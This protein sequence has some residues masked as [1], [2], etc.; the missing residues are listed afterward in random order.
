MTGSFSVT[1]KRALAVVTVVALGFGAYFLR[2]Y[3]LLI[4]VAAVLAYLF[5]PLY[6]RLRTSMNVGLSATVTLLAAVATVAIPLAGVIFLAV[7]QISQMVTSIGHWAE[8]TDSPRWRSGCSTRP[9][10]CSPA[11]R[12][13]TSR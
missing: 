6:Q 1:Q 8:Q 11:Y 2:H 7:L 9:T 5:T 3:L 10:R 12:S 4:A 13:W